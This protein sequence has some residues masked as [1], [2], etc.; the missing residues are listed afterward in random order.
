VLGSTSDPHCAQTGTAIESVV[1][2]GSTVESSASSP[3]LLAPPPDFRYVGL[4]PGVGPSRWSRVSAVGAGAAMGLATF[5]GVWPRVL[6]GS[7][8]GATLA[9]A[10]VRRFGGRARIRAWGARA[11]PMALVPWGILLGPEE[12]L[13]VLRW[14]GVRSVAVEMAQGWDQGT[15]MILFSVVVVA[16]ERE[17]FVA[18]ALDAISIERL[19]VHLPSYA[20]EASHGVAL[21]LEGNQRTEGPVEPDVEPLLSAARSFVASGRLTSLTDTAAGGYRGE[22]SR[23]ASPEV[24]ARLR[25]VLRDRTEHAVDPR[26]FAAALAAEVGARELTDDLVSLVQ[27]PHPVVASMAKAAALRLGASQQRVGS[28]DEVKPFLLERDAEALSSWVKG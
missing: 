14:N 16:T 2:L 9:A 10:L 22:P 11:E 20:R 17:R 7:L 23:S 8:V 4:S 26:P 12:G 18:H 1:R 15:P 6:A 5:E 13:R 24:L 25:S 21:D 28:L 3:P 27:S 19:V